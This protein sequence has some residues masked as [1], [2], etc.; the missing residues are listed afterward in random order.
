MFVVTPFTASKE[1]DG[2]A[3][4]FKGFWYLSIRGRSGRDIGAKGVFSGGE[5][6]G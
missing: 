5:I 6:S 2:N 1:W 4:V 3:V